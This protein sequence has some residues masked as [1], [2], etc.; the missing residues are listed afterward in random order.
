[1]KRP[2][3]IGMLATGLSCAAICSG[4]AVMRRSAVDLQPPHARPACASRSRPGPP[5][6][7]D[8][9]MMSIP[10]GA[11]VRT[12]EGDTLMRVEKDG[13]VVENGRVVGHA[14][15]PA[16]ASFRLLNGQWVFMDRCAGL[17]SAGTDSH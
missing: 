11:A 14:R 9:D 17:P 13:T 2:G 4:C 7:Q 8:G 15:P 12:I 6:V 10:P 16:K 5:V 1:M 3:I